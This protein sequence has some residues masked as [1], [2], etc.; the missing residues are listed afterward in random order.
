MKSLLNNGG[1][2][3]IRNIVKSENAESE[4]RQSEELRKII[5]D[6]EL[7][8]SAHFEKLL[9]QDSEVR[10]QL[11]RHDERLKVIEEDIRELTRKAKL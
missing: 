8:E 5:K 10:Q 11:A 2:D 9:Q 6:H 4:I 7:V 1:G 3:V